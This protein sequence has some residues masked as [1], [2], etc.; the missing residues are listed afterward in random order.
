MDRTTFK[1]EMQQL[2][3]LKADLCIT[4]KLLLGMRD[5]IYGAEEK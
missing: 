4:E 5:Q 1:R 3:D 2:F